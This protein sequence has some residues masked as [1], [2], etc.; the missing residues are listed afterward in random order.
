[1]GFLQNFGS[2][3]TSALNFGKK[4]VGKGLAFGSKVAKTVSNVA[5]WAAKNGDKVLSL[6]EVI[7]GVK[8]VDAPLRSALGAAQSIASTAGKAA[9]VMSMGAYLA[10]NRSNGIEKPT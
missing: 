1:M 2:K 4:V 9:D 6:A 10:G 8:A 7:P 3:A 5:D